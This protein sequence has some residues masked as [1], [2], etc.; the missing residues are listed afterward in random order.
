MIALLGPYPLDDGAGLQE[1]H[2][3]DLHYSGDTGIRV[4]NCLNALMCGK[5]S[6][7]SEGIRTASVPA[8]TCDSS[9]RSLSGFSSS[10]MKESDSR[11]STF[12]VL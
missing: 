9:S 6:S 11:S 2:H 4:I 5:H 8:V 7:L 3:L 12:R 1:Q 10:D